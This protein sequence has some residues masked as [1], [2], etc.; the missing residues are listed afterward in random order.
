MAL[1]Y[2]GKDWWSAVSNSGTD[3]EFAISVTLP[4]SLL[5]LAWS[6]RSTTNVQSSIIEV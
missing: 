2:S 5:E 4:A 3:D 6:E 1:L